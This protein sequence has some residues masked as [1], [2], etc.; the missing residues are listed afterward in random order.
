MICKPFPKK[1]I[2]NG[3][4]YRKNQQ[5]AAAFGW[6]TTNS[7][8]ITIPVAYNLHLWRWCTIGSRT[9]SRSLTRAV[10]IYISTNPIRIHMQSVSRKPFCSDLLTRKSKKKT[11][12]RSRK[13]TNFLHEKKNGCMPH[14]FESHWPNKVGN[15]KNNNYNR[16]ILA[17]KKIIDL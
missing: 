16:N 4:F 10:E 11:I 6:F 8:I 7:Q 15:I 5:T 1:K 17:K 3:S 9:H 13:N 2:Q 14:I 12:R